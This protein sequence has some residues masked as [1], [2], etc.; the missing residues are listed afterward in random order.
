MKYS[1]YVNYF[2][3]AA[4]NN[5]ALSHVDNTNHTFYEID[6][7]DV[8]QESLKFKNKNKEVIL[9]LES[10]QKKA[11]DNN[12]DNLRKYTSGAFAILKEA[13]I[14][15]HADRQLALD[16]TEEVSEQI[17]S[18]I[19]NDAKIHLQNKLHPWKLKGFDINSL[20]WYK[21]GPMFTN[22]YGWRVEFTFNDT[23]LNNLHLDATKWNNE[24]P[25]TI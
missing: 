14:G 2:K 3:T 1:E 18:K 23:F 10:P 9:L 11:G 25:H 5:I 16:V 12:G 6:I 20:S 7:I 19:L 4:I 21:I 15:D 22:H 13:K 24:T 8:A 17:A